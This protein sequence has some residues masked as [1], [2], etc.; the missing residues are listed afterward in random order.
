VVHIKPSCV[1]CGNNPGT[2]RDHVP[3]K[4]LFAK[5]RPHLV[6][7]PCCDECR[8]GQSLD[9]E[10]F[11]RM[12]SMKNG[13]VDNLSSIS[14]RSSALRSLVK[15]DKARFTGSLLNN[16]REVAA[17]TPSGIFL[18]THLSYDVDLARLCRV[19][20]RTTCGLYSHEFGARMPK[21]HRCRTYAVDGF[22][23]AAPEVLDQIKK[24]RSHAM[25]GERR[26]L[27]EGVFTYWFRRIDGPEGATAWDFRV[28]ENVAFFAFT[29]PS[30][31]AK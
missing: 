6:T 12:I 1:Y 4:G 13:T 27:G 17:F 31:E 18:G 3:P 2:T 11:V 30:V 20:E 26:D 10:Y 8:K 21:G 25:A 22:G 16:I 7:V 23:A 14:A 29:G 19:I 24:I 15:P 5:P 9:D 28:F